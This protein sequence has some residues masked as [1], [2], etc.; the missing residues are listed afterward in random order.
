MF[1]ERVTSAAKNN[2]MRAVVAVGL[3][4]TIAGIL[5]AGGRSSTPPQ[6]GGWRDLDPRELED[7]PSADTALEDC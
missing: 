3:A 4:G 7:T 2:L 6:R 1:G 5:R